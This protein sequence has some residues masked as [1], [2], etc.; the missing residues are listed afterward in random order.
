M[1]LTESELFSSI[2]VPSS[3]LRT[4][5]K[6]YQ[7]CIASNVLLPEGYTEHFYHVGN[8]KELVKC[9]QLHQRESVILRPRVILKLDS[10]SGS[11]DLFVPEARSS[12]ESQQD[13]ESHGETR[14]NTGDYRILGI[15]ISTV[16]LQDARRQNNVTK[17][18][19]M[20]EK[21]QH[22]EQFFKGMSQQQ[23]INRPS[24]ESQK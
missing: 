22:K 3:N 15:S 17:L 7:S 1:N 19:E 18:I 23:E 24:E 2:L 4:L 6:Y 8:E 14:S 5:R 9:N 16:K 21:H 10:Q 13:A 20:F 12:W 11:Q